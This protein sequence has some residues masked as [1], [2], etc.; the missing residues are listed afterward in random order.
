[1]CDLS[2][3]KLVPGYIK[4]MF[5]DSPNGGKLRELIYKAANEQIKSELISVI[6]YQNKFYVSKNVKMLSKTITEK[7]IFLRDNAA[8]NLFFIRFSFQVFGEEKGHSVSVVYDIGRETWELFDSAM[9]GE[10]HAVYIAICQFLN[11][12][13][14]RLYRIMTKRKQAYN[15]KKCIILHIP[16]ECRVNI[17]GMY[18]TCLIWTH[19]W[20]YLRSV[21]YKT[22]PSK[23][24]QIIG[25]LNSI[26]K[27][28]VLLKFVQDVYYQEGIE[29]YEFSL[30]KLTDLPVGENTELLNIINKDIM[31]HGGDLK[32]TSFAAP[33]LPPLIDIIINKVRNARKSS[34]DKSPERVSSLSL[35]DIESSPDL[36]SFKQQFKETVTTPT[37]KQHIT[38]VKG[39]RI[40]LI[41]LSDTSSPSSKK[42]RI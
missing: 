17:Q 23:L 37:Q 18:P 24:V 31:M 16:G 40:K 28:C 33:I 6:E 7:I 10:N 36:P 41:E 14:F 42:R 9:I 38:K 19:V 8:S 2:V 12:I 34:I 5:L 13:N 35:S 39:T 27:I 32:N 3:F 15:I 4:T 30:D 22:S 11:N 20:F 26:E 21:F 29:E 1:M 25:T